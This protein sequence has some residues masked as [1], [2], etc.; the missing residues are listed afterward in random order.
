MNVCICGGGSLG[1]VIA[2]V[3]ASKG[4]Q[5]SI[6]TRSPEKW[7]KELTIDNCKGKII[8]GSLSNITDNPKDV[9]PFSDLVCYVNYMIDGHLCGDDLENT[10]Y[11]SRGLFKELIRYNGYRL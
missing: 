11:I 3:M 10:G 8:K 4:A 9:I 7:S 6:L 2:G 5:V 1:H